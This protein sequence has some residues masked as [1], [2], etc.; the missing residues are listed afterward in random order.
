M[1]PRSIPSLPRLAGLVAIV[2]LGTGVLTQIGQGS[3]PEPWSPVANAI[4]PWLTV[5]FL[6]GALM[7]T[8][9]GAAI[10]GV[11]TLLFALAGYYA[12]TELRFGMGAGTGSLVRW[13]VGA[14]VGGPV[15]GVAGHSWRHG[16]GVQR[17][18]GVGLLA[19]VFI[20]EGA[21]QARVVAHTE[22]GVSF[23][24]IGLLIPIILG[25]SMAGRLAAYAATIPALALGAV[26]FV[27]LIV[28]DGVAA[29]LS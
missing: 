13:G 29:R 10:A 26:G 9:G 1:E 22:A 8:R 14:G 11:V 28:L 27:A 20:A 24:A 2:G 4:S 16:A 17:A 6:V 23:V 5:A 3:L 21:Y 19:A 25:G 7:P 15:F 12:M 18:L